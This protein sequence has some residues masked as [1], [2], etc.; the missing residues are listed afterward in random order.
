MRSSGVRGARALI[1][2]IGVLVATLAYA[3]AQSSRAGQAPALPSATRTSD[4]ERLA[5]EAEI[6]MSRADLA[7]RIRS[8]LGRDFGGAWFEPATAQLHVGITS[9]GS[10]Q[11]AESVA[12]EAGLSAIVT[13]TPVRSTWAELVAAQAKWDRR[14]TDLFERGLVKTW[15]SEQDNAVRVELASSVPAATLAALEREAVA[16]D[17]AVSVVPTSH[18]SFYGRAAAQCKAFVTEQAYC[19]PTIVAGVKIEGEGGTRCTAGP[20][21]VRKDRSDDFWATETF[22]LTAGHCLSGGGALQK[23][24]SFNKNAEKKS[25]GKTFEYKHASRDVGVVSVEMPYWANETFIPVVPAVAEWS[26]AA[27]SEPFT[28]VGETE[29]V[30]NAK[31]CFSGQVSGTKCGEIVTKN[32]T[33]EFGTGT[34][35]SELVEVK[36]LTVQKG[37]SG[38]PWYSGE[39]AGAGMVEGTLVGDI[40]ASTHPVFE[41]LESAFTS[42]TTKFELLSDANEERHAFKFGAES[43]PVVLTGKRSGAAKHVFTTHFGAISCNEVTFTKELTAVPVALIRVEPKYAGCTTAMGAM[44]PVDTN[45]C[46]FEFV[47]STFAGG[48]FEGRV[49]L[50]CP[51]GQRIDITTPG[52]RITVGSQLKKG[53][54]TYTNIGAGATREISVD[55]NLV[56]LLYEEH[57]VTPL[58]NCAQNTKPTTSGTYTGSELVTG[59][60][61]AAAHDGIFVW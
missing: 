3:D 43:V 23:W 41:T 14:L 21:V 42:F 8:A 53:A 32:A 51:S 39:E 47:P 57:N 19:N 12:A 25:L 36:G 17:V 46:A 9:P 31:T 28:V 34:K 18:G 49:H 26:A 50:L 54:V 4:R 44:V 6:A 2:A 45:G 61:K 40:T 24:Y 33:V 37:D 20:A 5:T 15:I 10:G 56:N 22:V 55:L 11:V 35:I 16:G 30:Q 58:N 38:G 52:C 59:E 1:A 7:G 29:P 60:T 27:E 48:N 13:A